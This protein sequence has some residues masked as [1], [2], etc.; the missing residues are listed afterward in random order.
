MAHKSTA[1]TI[2]GCR[3]QRGARGKYLLV[4]VRPVPR[5]RLLRVSELTETECIYIRQ[6]RGSRPDAL[7]IAVQSGLVGPAD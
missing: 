7:E 6:P 3:P 1:F 5:A 4:E 2:V